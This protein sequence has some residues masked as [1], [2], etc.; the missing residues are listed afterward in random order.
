MQP[1]VGKG[2]FFVWTQPHGY[3]RE[4]VTMDTMNLRLIYLYKKK[5]V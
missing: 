2:E 3:L 4:E 5:M 1:T